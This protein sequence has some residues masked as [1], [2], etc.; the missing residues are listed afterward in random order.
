MNESAAVMI[1]M[2]IKLK[3]EKTDVEKWEFTGLLHDLDIDPNPGTKRNAWTNRGSNARGI[4]AGGM[5][6]CK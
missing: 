2:A 3:L 5:F 1:V 6:A 4:L